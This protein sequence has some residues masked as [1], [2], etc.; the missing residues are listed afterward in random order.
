[1]PPRKMLTK[2]QRA[3]FE[4]EIPKAVQLGLMDL[5]GQEVG[6]IVDSIKDLIVGD[7]LS[8]QVTFDEWLAYLREPSGIKVNA[9]AQEA[10]PSDEPEGVLSGGARDSLG[11]PV[12]DAAPSL[13]GPPPPGAVVPDPIIPEPLVEPEPVKAAEVQSAIDDLADWVTLANTCKAKIEKLTGHLDMAKTKITERLE[14]DGAEAGVVDGKVV[15]TW[16]PVER[17]VLNQKAWKLEHSDAEIEQYSTV[18][19]SYRFELK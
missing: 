13:A 7:I 14:Q 5:G 19:K 9:A 16:K 10:A 1:M 15:C 6:V 12:P 2:P 8:P 17:K 18:T 3:M 11:V 4:K